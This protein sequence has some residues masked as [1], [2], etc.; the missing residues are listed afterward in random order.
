MSHVPLDSGGLTINLLAS[1]LRLADRPSLAGYWKFNTS[2]LEIWDYRER[3][4]SLIKRALVGAVTG[5]RWWGSLMHIIRDF[6]TKYGQ[7]LNLDRGKEAKSIEDRLSRAVA[8]GESLNVELA[9]GDLER[10][11]SERYKGYVVRSR[12]KR[13]LNEAVKTT[14]LRVKKKYEGSPIGISFLSRPRTGD[15]CVRVVR[16]VMPF[17][18]TFGVALPAALISRSGSFVAILPTSPALGPAEA[19][20]CEGVVTECEVRDALK[21]VGLNKSPGL[22][23]LPYEVYLRMSHMFVPIL[24]DMFNHWFAQGAIPGSVTKGVITLLKKGDRHVWEG[25]DDYRPITA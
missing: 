18:R 11:S 3:L 5:N 13:V 10:E 2:L 8:G 23:G 4:E 17:G 9:R 21:Q 1:G 20:G 25:L 7:Q 22:D 12:L 15:C 19:A 24:T 16:Y 6:A 14:R